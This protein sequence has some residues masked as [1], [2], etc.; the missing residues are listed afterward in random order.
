MLFGSLLL[1]PPK[2][3]EKSFDQA[4]SSETMKGLVESG[5][6]VI[7]FSEYNTFAG[8][9]LT[10]GPLGAFLESLSEGNFPVDIPPECRD[11]IVMSIG[12]GIV[13][14]DNARELEN[15]LVERIKLKYKFNTIPGVFEFRSYHD[16]AVK[17]S[18]EGYGIEEA[19]VFA[20][21]LQLNKED[22]YFVL[23]IKTNVNFM[24]SKTGYIFNNIQLMG[25]QFCLFMQ[26]P[27]GLQLKEEL[28]TDSQIT[29]SFNEALKKRDLEVNFAK[30]YVYY[31]E[32][33]TE[34]DKI[35]ADYTNQVP[36]KFLLRQ[37]SKMPSL[38]ELHR[39][40]LEMSYEKLLRGPE[41]SPGTAYINGISN[42]L[43]S[44][45]PGYFGKNGLIKRF[46]V[47]FP[48]RKD[49]TINV[50]FS[51]LSEDDLKAG[52][53]DYKMLMDLYYQRY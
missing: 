2:R 6:M 26:N 14:A 19:R 9:C 30:A 42:S 53:F 44:K 7:V 23:R 11:E 21:E 27:K 18:R 47:G 52:T 34:K 16:F 39:I 48:Q 22:K 46:L 41:V 31:K 51:V 20:S 43:K 17:S 32:K 24:V 5:E 37:G 8:L 15:M 10:A 4:M 45:Y 29:E 50:F 36:R 33:P 40:F 3:I 1:C 28:Y 38:A 35:F 12:F 25:G 49:A 13:G